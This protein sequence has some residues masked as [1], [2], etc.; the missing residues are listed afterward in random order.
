MIPVVGHAEA[1]FDQV[2]DALRGP[3]VRGVAVLHRALQEHR[4]Q[5]RPLLLREFA[6]A[7]RS[8]LDFKDTFALHRALIAPTK[9]RTGIAADEAGGF[10]QVVPFVEKGQRFA[11]SIRKPF[12]GTGRTHGT[13]PTKRAPLY[14]ITYTDVNKEWSRDRY[15][16]CVARCR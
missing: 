7:A 2:G 6:R 12:R 1:L 13:P 16:V 5:S 8:A 4:G 11:A 3:Q 15:P 9:H 10:V 14:C